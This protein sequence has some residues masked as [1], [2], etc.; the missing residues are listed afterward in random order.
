MAESPPPLETKDLPYTA[1]P[2]P[3]PVADRIGYEDEQQKA[4]AAQPDEEATE[5]GKPARRKV[6]GT[7]D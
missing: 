4:G 6:T 5:A 7:K 1:V 2:A 3:V